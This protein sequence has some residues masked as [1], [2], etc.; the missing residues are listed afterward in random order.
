MI[1]GIGLDIIE[2]DRI[3]RASSKHG[4]LDKVFSPNEIAMFKQRN[5]DPK[6]IAGNFAAKEA[7]LKAFGIGISSGFLKEIEVLRKDTG[8]PYINLTADVKKYAIEHKCKKL[9]VSISNL[10]ELACAEVI[11]EA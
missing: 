2:I 3:K 10:K 9:F 7:T 6:V 4:F 5:F 11:I 1:Y 8:Q